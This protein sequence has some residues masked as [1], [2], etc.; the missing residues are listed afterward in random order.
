[1]TDAQPLTAQAQGKPPPWTGKAFRQGVVAVA[2]PYAAEAG[3]RI[4]EQGGKSPR[5][6]GAANFPQGPARAHP[7]IGPFLQRMLARPAVQRAIA[8]EQLP[9]PL[10]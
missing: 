4:L 7:H 5:R 8:A 6:L 3:A 10:V 2:N 9:E 1:M